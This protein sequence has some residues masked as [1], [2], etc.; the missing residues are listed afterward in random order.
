MADSLAYAHMAED[1]MPGMTV[2]VARDG[3]I[4]FSRGYG[5]ADVEMGADAS[6]E[7]VYAI[8][9]ITKQFTAAAIMRLVEQGKM[10]LDDPITHY[11][12]DYPVQGH[13]VTIRHLL[14]HTSGIKSY[15]ELDREADRKRRLGLSYEDMIDLFAKEPFDFPPGEQFR[16]NNS[17][18]YLLGQIIG[19]VTGRPY[20][21]YVEGELLQPLGLH[22]TLF[23]DP[24]RLNPKRAKGYKY[25]RSK[26]GKL[27]PAFRVRM[28]GDAAGGLSSTVGD[29]IRWTH[30][31]HSGQVV[32]QE[33]LQQMTSPTILPTAPPRTYGFG[34]DLAKLEDHGKVVHV[35]DT[36]GFNASL[37]HYP[38]DGLSVVVLANSDDTQHEKVEEFL[39]RAALDLKIPQVPDLPLT[40][41]EVGRYDGTYALQ[42]GKRTAELRVLAE[43]G[44]LKVQLGDG[45]AFRLRFQGNDSFVPVFDDNTRLVFIMENGRAEGI[46]LHQGERVSQ[47]KRKL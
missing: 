29:L 23:G 9:S 12:P 25:E 33:S 34:L 17:G 27:F 18:Y 28:Q 36:E 42:V 26:E 8:A 37:A 46:E 14:N 31:L 2:A 5:K 15:T 19:R 43:A 47:G 11:L 32:S 39:A 16:Y 41:E 22:Y 45:R 40:K 30:L 35:G 24:G 1:F 13:H 6:P 20:E 21:E 10:S 38:A 3:D 7:T 4:L 44:K